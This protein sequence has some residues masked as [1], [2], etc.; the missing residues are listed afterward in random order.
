[1]IR[2]DFDNLDDAIAYLK[3]DV[4]NIVN[5]LQDEKTRLIAKR[6]E[7]L[8]E[9]RSLKE[10][11]SKFEPYA[12]QDLDIDDL[13]ATKKQY[14]SQDSSVE[15]KYRSAYEADKQKF[16]QRLAAI[17]KEREAEKQQALKREQEAI[18]A[19][20]RSDAIAE[21]AKESHKI[22][23]PEQFWKLFGDG[24]VTR[25][26][27]TGKLVVEADYKKLEL[28]DYV[29]AIADSEDNLYHFKPSGASGSGTNPGVAPGTKQVNPWKTETFNLTEQGRLYR[30]NP[31]L[32]KRLMAEAKG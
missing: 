1:M 4:T 30:T 27:E 16:E 15:D 2:T 20:I 9:K 31:D 21:F 7:L 25:D 32:A 13:L 11:Y 24:K 12:D 29:K 22:R 14:E 5:G 19:Q 8:G 28:G 6:D 18:A 17:E 26:E 10:K 23:S 3:G